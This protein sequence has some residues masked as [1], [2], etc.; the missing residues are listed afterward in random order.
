[1]VGRVVNFPLYIRDV[2]YKRN[3]TWL[4]LH[5]NEAGYLQQKCSRKVLVRETTIKKLRVLA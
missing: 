4:Y 5:E 3:K 2:F 1:M